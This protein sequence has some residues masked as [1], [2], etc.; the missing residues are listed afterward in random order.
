MGNLLAVVKLN[1]KS[2]IPHDAAQN[3]FAFNVSGLPPGSVNMDDATA[4]ILDFYNTN[5]TF[6]GTT[7]RVCQYLGDSCSLAL[8]GNTISFYDVTGHLDGS[9][10]GAP[11]RVDTWTLAAKGGD[12]LPDEVAAAI[13]YHGDYGTDVEFAPGSRPRARDRGRLYVGPLALA[14]VTQDAT[15]GEPILS[16]AMRATLAGAA[17]RLKN[18]TT[19]TWSLWSRKKATMVPVT[20]GWVD[21]AFDSQRR[22]GNTATART[23]Y[24]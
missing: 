4:A 12:Q 5:V 9:A 19:V 17:Q 15:T 23:I 24:A 1:K 22:R 16:L 14:G 10:H 20:G 7:G 2:G 8:L 13:S 3:T 6:A 18:V 11:L 21:N